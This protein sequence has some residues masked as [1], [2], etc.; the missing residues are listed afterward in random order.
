MSWSHFW[1]S[2]TLAFYPISGGQERSDLANRGTREA[3]LERREGGTKDKK[4]RNT[5][6]GERDQG[7][8]L[9][10]KKMRPHITTGKCFVS[11][12]NN[13]C[14]SYLCTAY[15]MP[16]LVL[17]TTLINLGFSQHSE[18]D[19]I[20]VPTQLV[21]TMRHKEI[22]QVFHHRTTRQWTQGIWLFTITRRNCIWLDFVLVDLL[23]ADSNRIFKVICSELETHALSLIHT[24]G[25][26]NFLGVLPC[27]LY[28]FQKCNCK[29]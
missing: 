26:F 1:L 6:A 8:L 16:V 27:G 22:E 24:L 15:P 20:I 14:S 7:V 17:R 18:M 28:Y 10:R 9:S 2:H 5:K 13:N 4:E 11:L 21:R 23:R 29:I 25:N 19:T 3:F 12:S